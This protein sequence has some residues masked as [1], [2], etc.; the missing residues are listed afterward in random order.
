[1][2]GMDTNPNPELALRYLEETSN[3]NYIPKEMF[4]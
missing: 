4:S 1:M 3:N 2:D